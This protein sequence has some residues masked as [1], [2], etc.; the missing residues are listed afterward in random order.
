MEENQSPFCKWGKTLR[1]MQVFSPSGRAG[2]RYLFLFFSWLLHQFTTGPKR[3]Y[4]F[5]AFQFQKHIWRVILVYCFIFTISRTFVFCWDPQGHFRESF[6]FMLPR[7]EHTG[8]ALK[9]WD[10]TEKH[11]FHMNEALYLYTCK[12]SSCINFTNGNNFYRLLQKH[13]LRT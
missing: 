13:C 12:D 6:S 1:D 3:S 5:R 8:H 9:A 4:M 10:F 2:G 7:W 11:L